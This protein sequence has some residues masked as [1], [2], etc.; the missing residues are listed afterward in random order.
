MNDF[1][2]TF[3]IGFRF[4]IAFFQIRSLI[5]LAERVLLMGMVDL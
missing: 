1:I 4:K 2:Q 5:K 3:C